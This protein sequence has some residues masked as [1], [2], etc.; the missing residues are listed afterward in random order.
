MVPYFD[1]SAEISYQISSGVVP[2]CCCF[3]LFVFVLFSFYLRLNWD[4]GSAEREK[5]RDRKRKRQT[6]REREGEI[7]RERRV[8]GSWW[9]CTTRSAA[10][11]IA[12]A[13]ASCSSRD[14]KLGP[15]KPP[16]SKT[17]VMQE[18]GDLLSA[19][20][21]SCLLLMLLRK[22]VWTQDCTLFPCLVT[23]TDMMLCLYE[24][25]GA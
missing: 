6:D 7:E 11:S 25:I 12:V 1:R 19:N 24:K 22:R 21:C 4:A 5:E 10:G 18:L 23:F 9:W 17:D 15:Y 2:F 20:S 14:G 16:L 13:S 3:Y 8:H